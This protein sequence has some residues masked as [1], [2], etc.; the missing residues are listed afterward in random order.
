MFNSKFVLGKPEVVSLQGVYFKTKYRVKI[1]KPKNFG[2]EIVDRLTYLGF[3]LR[4]VGIFSMT[5][6][7]PCHWWASKVGSTFIFYDHVGRVRIIQKN[8]QME[9]VR[10][11]NVKL[12]DDPYQHPAYKSFMG[13]ILDYSNA[14]ALIPFNKDFK[15]NAIIDA[16]DDDDKLEEIYFKACHNYMNRRYPAWQLETMYWDDPVEEALVY[17]DE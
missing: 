2:P 6:L 14:I 5:L 11:Y 8:K 15:L 12:V 3:E 9:F 13:V 17:E 4:R 10:R 16:N 1:K 7:L